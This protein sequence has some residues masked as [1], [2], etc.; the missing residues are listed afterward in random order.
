MTQW[1]WRHWYCRPNWNDGDLWDADWQ[2][3]IKS[4]NIPP[5]VPTTIEFKLGTDCRVV[6]GGFIRTRR[7]PLDPPMKR[8]IFTTV[9]ILWQVVVA[10]VGRRMNVLKPVSSEW[11][12]VVAEIIWR[13]CTRVIGIS[14]IFL[15]WNGNLVFERKWCVC[16]LFFAVIFFAVLKRF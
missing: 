10:V 8:G 4:H 1:P 13:E 3:N 5:A 2:G 9:V 11:V 6:G 16:N 7:T 14:L 15:L 12:H